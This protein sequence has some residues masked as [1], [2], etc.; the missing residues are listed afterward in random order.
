MTK[1]L[2]DFALFTVASTI[3]AITAFG[4]LGLDPS[5]AHHSKSCESTQSLDVKCSKH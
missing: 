5:E 2:Q 3:M 1:K 4:A